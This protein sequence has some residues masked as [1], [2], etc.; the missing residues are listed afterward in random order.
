[1]GLTIN[2]IEQIIKA[3][4]ENEISFQNTA[5]IGHQAYWHC[6][7]DG[8]TNI[9]EKYNLKNNTLN[10][11]NLDFLRNGNYSDQFFKDLGAKNLDIYDANRYENA[12]HIHDFNYEIPHDYKNKYNIVYDG[13]SLEHIYNSPVAIKNF[14]SMVAVNGYY[15]SAVPCNNWAGHGFYQFSP[16]FFFRSLSLE[17]GFSNTKIYLYHETGLSNSREYID[18]KILGHRVEFN[19][20][21]PLSIFAI[22]KKIEDV[23]LFKKFPQQSDYEFSNW[24]HE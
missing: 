23:P 22:S 8:Y 7:E 5:T 16:E 19:D 20:A 6:H 13:G 4:I 10:K 9:I 18:P 2:T 15:I 1:M 21:L 11:L 24:T 17:N 12:T 14:M 3:K